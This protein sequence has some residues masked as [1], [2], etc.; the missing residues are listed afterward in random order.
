M[1]GDSLPLFFPVLIF[2]LVLWLIP[3][4]V[5]KYCNRLSTKGARNGKII[6][7]ALPIIMA[8][9]LVIYRSRAIMNRDLG[10]TEVAKRLGQTEASLTDLQLLLTGDGLGE[11]ALLFL[12]SFSL[13]TRYL[14]SLKDSSNE[15]KVM[16]SNRVMIYVAA[17]ALLSFWV[18]FPESNYYSS[19]SLPLEPTMSAS[20]DYNLFMVIIGILIIAFSGEL[21]AI[22]TFHYSDEG[23]KTLQFRAS[24]KMYIVCA[25]MLLGFYSSEYFSIDWVIDNEFGKV[26][27][28]LIFLSQGLVLTFICAP[29]QQ[30]DDAL[31]V[32][33]GRSRSFAIM[34]TCATLLI[35]LVTSL[36]LRTSTVFDEGNRYLHEA[37]WLAASVMILISM[38]QILPRYGF[39][40]AARPEYWWLRMMLVFAPAVILIFNPLAIFLIPSLW[41]VACCSIILP[42]TIECDAKSPN[43][44]QSILLFGLVVILSTGLI[45][46]SNPVSNFLLFGPV[47]L[48][49]PYGL[50]KLHISRT[51]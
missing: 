24:V 48:I 33:D 47:I 14:P 40:A 18:F 22:S 30:F 4:K 28:A 39:D 11:I 37:F 29:S 34:A 50:M 46:S 25:I 5:D 12:L 1:L 26:K 8:L 45:F 32:G 10:E 43:L 35:I 42:S 19:D 13:W 27:M 21:F 44:Q 15:L 7:R 9:Y 41:I 2:S 36:L 49:M 38:T 16:I 17:C 23:I 31:K 6:Y 51:N 20:G 3:N